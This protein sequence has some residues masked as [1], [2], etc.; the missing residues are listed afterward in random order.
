M[1]GTLRSATRIC[2]GFVTETSCMEWLHFTKWTVQRARF[3]TNS[4]QSFSTWYLYRVFLSYHCSLLLWQLI[5]LNVC[6]IWNHLVAFNITHHILLQNQTAN[7]VQEY[8]VQFFSRH[9]QSFRRPSN[10]LYHF[11]TRRFIV[12]FI[13]SSHSLHLFLSQLNPV[14][15]LYLRSILILSRPCHGSRG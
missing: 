15:A 8:W 7:N 9:C 14:H 4:S 6:A 11:R 3:Q 12:V 5:Y 10:F 2:H 13:G 1:V